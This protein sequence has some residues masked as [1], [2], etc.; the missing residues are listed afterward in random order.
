[1]SSIRFVS[2]SLMATALAVMAGGA[3]A[4]SS[5]MPEVKVVA[6]KAVTAKGR[7]AAGRPVE[8]IQL[9]HVVAYADI[10]IATASGAAVLQQ[11]VKDAA[12]SVCKELE[13]LYPTGTSAELGTGSCVTDAVRATAPQ[14]QAAIDAAE[15]G[16]RSAAA[17]K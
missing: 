10:N 16:I 13:K 17:P 1:M 9:S 8:V 4:Q 6:D 12:T 2:G 5:A 3:L 7:T 11:R 14:V 15:K